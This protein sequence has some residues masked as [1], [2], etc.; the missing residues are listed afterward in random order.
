M[1]VYVTVADINGMK[2]TYL[3]VRGSNLLLRVLVSIGERGV[4]PW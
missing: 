3:P 1:P 4:A 2:Y